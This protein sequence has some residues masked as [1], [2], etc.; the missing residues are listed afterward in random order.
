MNKYAAV[1]RRMAIIIAIIFMNEFP[2]N[3]RFQRLAADTTKINKKGMV[4]KAMASP[5]SVF[6]LVITTD[7]QTS[8]I[9][10]GKC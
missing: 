1:I 4:H 8:A 6:G 7:M 9:A 10:R 3:L 5:I 2:P